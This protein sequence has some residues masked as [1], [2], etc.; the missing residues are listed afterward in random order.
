MDESGKLLIKNNVFVGVSGLI[1]SEETGV[2]FCEP[3]S[4]SFFC[5]SSTDSDYDDCDF[6][7]FYVSDYFSSISVS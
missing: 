2:P 7:G 5:F 3:S 1:V 4:T 6:S